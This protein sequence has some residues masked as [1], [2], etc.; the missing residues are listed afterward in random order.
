MINLYKVYNF[1][2]RVFRKNLILALS[3]AAALVIILIL[4]IIIRKLHAKSVEKKI[5]EESARLKSL[6]ELNLKYDFFDIKKTYKYTISCKSK[7]QFDRFN[8]EEYFKIILK[9]NPALIT[10]SSLA[11]K[12]KN[13]YQKYSEDF[14]ELPETMYTKDFWVQ[15]EK[16]LL[17]KNKLKPVTEFNVIL[18]WTYVSPKGRNHYSKRFEYKDTRIPYYANKARTEESAKD[19]RQAQIQKER[20]LMT[21]DLRYRILKRDNFKCQI[22]GSTQADGV[23]L[24]VDHII[25]V[26]KGGKTEPDNLQTLCDRC[27]R[28]KSNKL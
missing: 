13:K 21:S 2:N 14:S 24:E 12:N 17:E 27:N 4:V 25:P 11:A 5:I 28:G 3:I 22:C 7:Q 20:A 26:S 1:F 9:E 19:S 18:Q 15:T 8:S 23:K 10:L 16:S 6:N